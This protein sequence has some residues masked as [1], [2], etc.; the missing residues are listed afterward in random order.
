MFIL[1]FILIATYKTHCTHYLIL[2]LIKQCGQWVLYVARRK[3]RRINLE[4]NRINEKNRRGY[5]IIICLEYI[6]CV[7]INKRTWK[8]ARSNNVNRQEGTDSGGTTG[9]DQ[10]E[11]VELVLSLISQEIISWFSWVKDL[12]KNWYLVQ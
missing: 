9:M 10:T 2:I 12:E 7:I 8:M 11:V 6:I 4:R 1:L 5:I 3:K